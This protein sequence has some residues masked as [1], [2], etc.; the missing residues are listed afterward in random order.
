MS[1]VGSRVAKSKLAVPYGEYVYRTSSRASQSCGAR[2]DSG[3]CG[4]D[5]IYD[6]IALGRVY[7][8]VLAQ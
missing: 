5:I 3:T 8:T 6:N 1:L 2:I 4:E 7:G